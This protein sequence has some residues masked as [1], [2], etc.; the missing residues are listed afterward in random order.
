[1]GC[2]GL[3]LLSSAVRPG[4]AAML[5]LHT[6]RLGLLDIKVCGVQLYGACVR[7]CAC[8]TSAA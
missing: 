7:P 8:A 2:L 6:T 1:M 3:G 4:S 5:Q